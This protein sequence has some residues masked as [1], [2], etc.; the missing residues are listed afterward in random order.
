VGASSAEEKEK[1]ASPE[2]LFKWLAL[3]MDGL[4]RVPG[5]KFRFGLNP[6]IDF[7]PG[8]G[9]V[10]AAFVSTSVLIYAVTRDCRKSFPPAWR[11]IF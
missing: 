4:L 1:R 2:L 9:D 11:S 5:T 10:S 6:L 7:V 8:I 3:I